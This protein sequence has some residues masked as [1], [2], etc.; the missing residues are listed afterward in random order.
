MFS[1]FTSKAKVLVAGLGISVG[2]LLIGKGSGERAA[3]APG[4]PNESHAA[5]AVDPDAL[6][7]QKFSS[8]LRKV[9]ADRDVPH[10][11]ASALHSQRS[12]EAELPMAQGP[13]ERSI[14]NFP[15]SSVKR[16]EELAEKVSR[17][18]T[19]SKACKSSIKKFCYEGG[20]YRPNLKSEKRA[21]RKIVEK[22]VKDLVDDSSLRTDEQNPR[23]E[24]ARRHVVFLEAYDFAMRGKPTGFASSV[25][26]VE[27]LDFSL[28]IALRPDPERSL[29]RFEHTYQYF[30]GECALPY[31]LAKDLALKLFDKDE[32]FEVIK[33]HRDRVGE[34]RGRGEDLNH[35]VRRTNNEFFQLEKNIDVK[36]PLA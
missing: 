27:I 24:L 34:L 28:K 26:R 25:P 35:A 21:D 1:E 30:V 29:A 36:G 31:D 22:L 12:Q 6:S 8:N 5:S 13:V 7:S 19:E 4:N 14:E 20:P 33:E 2:S 3:E 18:P 10:L 32:A 9:V 23:P 15:L 17:S 11:F 16:L